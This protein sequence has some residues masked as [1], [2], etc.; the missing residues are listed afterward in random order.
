MPQEH[1]KSAIALWNE[2]RVYCEKWQQFSQKALLNTHKDFMVSV[3]FREGIET[4]YYW[5]LNEQMEDC[6]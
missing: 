5:L 2:Q 6:V 1:S 3:V 4:F